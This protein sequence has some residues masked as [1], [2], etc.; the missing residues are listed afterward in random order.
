MERYFPFQPVAGTENQRPSVSSGKFPFEPRFPFAIQP[1][2]PEILAK[3]KAPHITIRG[4][5]K[6]ID[7]GSPAGF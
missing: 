4:N 5:K 3:W 1:V 2:G 6:S 7:E